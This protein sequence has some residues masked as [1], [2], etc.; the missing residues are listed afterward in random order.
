MSRW[1]SCT[2]PSNS[3]AAGIW[4]GMEVAE[5]A[6][7]LSGAVSDVGSGVEVAVGVGTRAV[8]VAATR[9]SGVEPCE[10]LKV[11]CAGGLKK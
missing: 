7:V 8:R 5:G 6:M 10:G 9:A 2:T 3:T 1:Y 11:V 4:V